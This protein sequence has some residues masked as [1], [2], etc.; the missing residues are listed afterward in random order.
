MEIVSYR[1]RAEVA[2][3]QFIPAPAGAD[4]VIEPAQ[5]AMVS[6]RQVSFRRG[7]NSVSAGI[8]RR[9]LLRFGNTL[10]GPAIVEQLDATTVIPPGWRGTIDAYGNLLLEQAGGNA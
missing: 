1:V 3:P 2:V 8:W 9:D 4:P 5:E 7:E 6:E 10:S